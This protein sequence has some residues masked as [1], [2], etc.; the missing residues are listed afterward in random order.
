MPDFNIARFASP[1]PGMSLTRE[2]GS[3]PWEKPAK[4]SNA[5]DALDFYI[6]SLSSPNIIN[7]MLNVLE[8]GFPVTTFIDS[9]II[10]GVMEG[11]HTIDVGVLISPA[12]FRFIVG[13]ADIADVEYK[14]GLEPRT[15]EDTTLIS[16]AVRA[17]EE[18]PEEKPDEL[19]ET[20]TRG[21]EEA[22]KGLM[23]KPDNIKQGEE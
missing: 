19:I 12:L 9:L 18:S 1:I 10:T 22:H 23:I 6:D 17:A 4:Y 7:G 16:A 14:S 20:A 21:L 15:K 8:R 2:P 11:L 13:I 3:R 5:E